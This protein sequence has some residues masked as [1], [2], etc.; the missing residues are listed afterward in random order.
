MSDLVCGTY[1]R[2]FYKELKLVFREFDK[3]ISQTQGYEAEQVSVWHHSQVRVP[4]G[5]P[6]VVTGPNFLTGH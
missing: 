3:K 6:T 4:P 1:K 2:L 5:K